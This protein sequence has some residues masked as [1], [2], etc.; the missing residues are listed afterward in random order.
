MS[1]RTSLTGSYWCIWMISSF[2]PKPVRNI[3]LMSML[4]FQRLLENKPYVKAEKCEFHSSSITFFSY[5]LALGQVKTDLAK[6][7]AFT[8]W[9]TP[10]THCRFQKHLQWVLGIANFYRRFICN[11]SQVAAPLKSQHASGPPKL[12]LYSPNWSICS[13][14]RLFGSPWSQLSLQRWT[15]QKL[16]KGEVNDAKWK[17]MLGGGSCCCHG[18]CERLWFPTRLWFLPLGEAWSA[19]PLS[20]P[21]SNLLGWI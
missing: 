17:R 4:F 5:I 9:P 7:K 11:Y 13:P 19:C 20:T 1:S 8:E 15:H 12:K 10:C 18:L 14:Q 16:E 6:V 2:F 3:S 21:D